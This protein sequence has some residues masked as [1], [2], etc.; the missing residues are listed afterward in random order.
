MQGHLEHDKDT[1]LSA[2]FV[3]SLKTIRVL[4]A[5]AATLGWDLWTED[6]KRVNLLADR[7]PEPV[8]TRIPPEA[9]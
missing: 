4:T 1:T 3:V 8:Y 5:A 9:G 7:L 2:A 6:F